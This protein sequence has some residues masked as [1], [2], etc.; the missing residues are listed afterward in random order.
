MAL[1]E[2]INFPA[3]SIGDVPRALRQLADE[4]DAGKFDDAHNLAWVIDCGNSRIEVGLCGCAP[5]GGITAHY[6]FAR[7][8]RKLEEL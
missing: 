4:I 5:E 8:M 3:K 2:I 1:A 7:G 6:L